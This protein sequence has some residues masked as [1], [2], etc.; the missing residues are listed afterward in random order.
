MYEG[1]PDWPERDRFWE[2]VEK[3]KAT[4]LYTAP[5]AIRSFMKWG[6]GAFRRSTTF[7]QSAAFRLGRRADQPGGV[8]LVPRK[9]RRRA[10]PCR[11]YVVADGNGRPHDRAAPRSAA[12]R[13]PGSATRPFPGIAMDVVDERGEIRPESIES[14]LLVI[15]K[16]WP[17]MLRTLWNDDKRYQRCLLEQNSATKIFILPETARKKDKDGYFWLLGRVDDIM[18]VAGHNISTME[19]ES[20][21]VDHPS[22][23]GI[24]RDR[25]HRR[26]QRTGD[27][28]VRDGERR[29]RGD[30]GTGLRS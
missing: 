6:D 10:L 26:C 15:R 12:R 2:I 8:A 27:C 25:A 3:Y 30:F 23:G 11:R 7:N 13:R 21:L 18:L 14:G 9:R 4:I 29:L 22:R 5:T 20:A 16:P 19:V 28:G 17:S 24:R 1:A